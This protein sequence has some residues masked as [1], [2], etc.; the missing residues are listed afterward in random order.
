MR[1]IMGMIVR[2]ADGAPNPQLELV[3]LAVP[4][5]VHRNIRLTY[6][7]ESISAFNG[8]PVGR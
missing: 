6:V 7:A 8:A 2:A 5:R 3:R 1:Q 4:W